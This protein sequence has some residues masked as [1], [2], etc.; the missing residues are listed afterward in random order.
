M[1]PTTTRSIA[2]V[3]GGMTSRPILMTLQ[4][5]PQT[6]MTP[7]SSSHA[8]WTVVACGAVRAGAASPDATGPESTAGASAGASLT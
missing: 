6:R 7:R 1:A 3:I 2:Y 8:V 5:S 4:W